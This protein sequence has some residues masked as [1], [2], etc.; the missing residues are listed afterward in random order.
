ME[1]DLISSNLWQDVKM[2][3]LAFWLNLE[4]LLHYLADIC[5]LSALF[6][7][8]FIYCKIIVIRHISP[9][10]FCFKLCNHFLLI[11]VVLHLLLNL[12]HLN[13]HLLIILY[14]AFLNSLQRF[15]KFSISTLLWNPANR[16]RVLVRGR[17]GQV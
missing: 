3:K 2:T 13:R 6:C 9:S 15:I 4:S 16:S 12:L 14:F 17:S 7:V 8:F 5:S 10:K 1:I 11:F